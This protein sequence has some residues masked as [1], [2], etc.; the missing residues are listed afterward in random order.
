MPFLK[1]LFKATP[2]DGHIRD[3]I[4]LDNSG[5]IVANADSED[6]AR[7]SSSEEEP[8]VPST[9][10]LI[11][12]GL[13]SSL[14]PQPV[15]PFVRRIEQESNLAHHLVY[16]ARNGVVMV[17]LYGLVWIL[18]GKPCTVTSNDWNNRRFRYLPSGLPRLRGSQTSP[19]RN[20]QL[21]Q[22]HWDANIRIIMRR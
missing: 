1:A 5:F 6:Y 18:E 15:R 17:H 12:P 20:M 8:S 10:Y 14:G 21:S 16:P 9:A 13:A 2:L 7:T 4:R 3:C 22:R 11:T 19:A